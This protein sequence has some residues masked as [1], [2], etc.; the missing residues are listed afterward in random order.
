[1]SPPYKYQRQG[2]STG[3]VLLL[4]AIW[5]ILICAWVLLNA[6]PLIIGIGTVCT[7]PALLDVIRNPSSGLC[8]AQDNLSWHSGP[9]TADIPLSEISGVRLDTRLDFSVRATVILKNGRK[10][11]IPFEATPPHQDFERALNA[12]NIKTERH[13]FSLRQ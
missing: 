13:H 2:R 1:M 5:A 9:R 8:L 12:Q 11:R 7:L 10:V 4:V 3:A 6:A